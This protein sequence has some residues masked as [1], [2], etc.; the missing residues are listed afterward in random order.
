MEGA[1]AS[2]SCRKML[3]WSSWRRIAD[4]FTK[5]W[6]VC[7]RNCF[8]SASRRPFYFVDTIHFS[9]LFPALLGFPLVFQVPWS[10]KDSTFLV[11]MVH[12]IIIITKFRGC[13][14]VI[15]WVSIFKCFQYLQI[16]IFCFHFLVQRFLLFSIAR[17]QLIS[18]TTR[19]SCTMLNE[20][21]G[22]KRGWEDRLAL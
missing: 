16:Y 9:A 12:S 17:F 2:S 22:G 1:C 6:D 18:K 11:D 10:E 15:S 4:P 5:Q 8:L 19:I 21:R 20:L 14:Q 7:M 13:F 3:E